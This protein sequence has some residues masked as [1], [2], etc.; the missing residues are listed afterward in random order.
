M[1]LETEVVKREAEASEE[2][3]PVRMYSS[4]NEFRMRLGPRAVNK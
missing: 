3:K 4:R 2:L 1:L